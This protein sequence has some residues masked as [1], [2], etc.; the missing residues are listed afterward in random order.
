MKERHQLGTRCERTPL[1]KTVPPHERVLAD[2]AGIDFVSHLFETNRSDRYIV[3]RYVP[4]RSLTGRRRR[5]GH[6]DV[7]HRRCECVLLPHER[8][9]RCGCG[10]RAGRNGRYATRRGGCAAWR[11]GRRA[12]SRRRRR[13]SSARRSGFVRGKRTD[14]LGASRHVLEAVRLAC[15]NGDVGVLPTAVHE[16]LAVALPARKPHHASTHLFIGNLVLGVAAIALE[17][18]RFHHL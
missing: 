12:P 17:S 14:R 13:T 3:D 9:C 18:H 15:G 6:R 11:H 10:R 2:G 5:I 7:G 4:L 8:A 1:L 16:N